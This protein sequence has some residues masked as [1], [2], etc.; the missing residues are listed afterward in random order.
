MALIN[1]PECDRSV[2]DKALTCPGCG[3]PISSSNINNYNNSNK[4]SIESISEDA[5]ELEQIPK[6]T[7]G[8]E[9]ECPIF[10]TDMRIGQQITNWA[11]DAAFT[12]IYDQSIN[13]ISDI[14]SGKITVTLHTHGIQMIVGTSFFEIHNSQIISI[15][16]TTSADI[17]QTNKSVIGRAVAGAL[18]MG[19]LGAIIGGMSGTGIKSKLGLSQY[20]VINFWDIDTEEAQSILISCDDA[21]NIDSFINRQKKEDNKNLEENRIATNQHMPAWMI[22]CIIVIIISIILIISS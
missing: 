13:S 17:I 8:N 16:K 12:G 6:K 20:V 11:F 15:I 4:H 10:P 22:I 19:P 5:F 7:L 1:C 2:S 9:L 3:L 21:Q 14:P 18:I